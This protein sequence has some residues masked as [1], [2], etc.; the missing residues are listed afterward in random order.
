MRNI[1][2][3]VPESQAPQVLLGRL[4]QVTLSKPSANDSILTCKFG[5]FFS[6]LEMGVTF[7]EV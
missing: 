7:C 5:A 6:K 4:L 3:Q 2:P 1:V